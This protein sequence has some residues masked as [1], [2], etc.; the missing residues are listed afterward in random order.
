MEIDESDQPKRAWLVRNLWAIVIIVASLATVGAVAK[1][2]SSGS[3]SLRHEQFTIVSLQPPPLP[4]PP[5]Q[6]TAT[7][8]PQEDQQI[9]QPMMKEAET[10]S[11]PPKEEPP[12]GTGIKGNGPDS[13]GLGG[14]P[15]NGRIGGAAAS[16]SRW[17]WYANQ[18]ATRIQEAMRRNRK[19]RSANLSVDVRVWP[20]TTGRVSRAQL[21]RST[22]DSD[23]D[24]VLRDQV[25]TGLQLQEA[26]PVGMPA[27][28]V[29]HVTARQ[30]R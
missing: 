25:L 12:L 22:G 27:P 17:G 30:P 11:E 3:T 9:E 24:N 5:P 14:K 6:N 23:L 20:D 18:V 10:K 1:L 26:P 21:A 8:P 19:T 28:I 16:G 29:L 7:P 2:A 4:P 15:G 13:Y